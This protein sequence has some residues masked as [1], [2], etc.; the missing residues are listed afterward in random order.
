[1]LPAAIFRM[2]QLENHNAMHKMA[3]QLS[4]RRSR[5]SYCRRRWVRRQAFLGSCP[6]QACL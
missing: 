4:R 6:L 5:Q 3:Q 1:M 2:R